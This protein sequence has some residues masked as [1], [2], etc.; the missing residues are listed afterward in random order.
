MVTSFLIYCSAKIRTTWRAQLALHASS[1]SHI[2]TPKQ[3]SYIHTS[4]TGQK[5]MTIGSTPRFLCS[6]NAGK[7]HTVCHS[8]QQEKTWRTL[9][10]NYSCHMLANVSVVRRPPTFCCQQHTI[11]Q[12]FCKFT[13]DRNIGNLCPGL[14]E[15]WFLLETKS[16]FRGWTIKLPTLKP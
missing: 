5:R 8:K 6:A 16:P 14:C 15:C 3:I 4:K 2:R 13:F 10:P 11:K 12:S 9:P 1:V 7:M